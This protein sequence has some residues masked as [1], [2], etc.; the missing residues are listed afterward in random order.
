MRTRSKL[1]L[2]AMTAT[3]FMSFAVSG[4]QA[5]RIFL[6]NTRYQAIWP[7]LTFEIQGQATISCPVTLEGS[8]HSATLSKVSGQLIGYVTSAK[9]RG[10]TL[11]DCNNT[12]QARVNSET[13]PWHMRYLSFRGTLPVI[14]GIT[15]QLIG[16]NFNV[17]PAGELPNCNART[18]AA[19]PGV[20]IANVVNGAEAGNR[21]ARTL[22]ADPTRTIPVGGSFICE[23][24]A[25][26]S[27]FRGT[28][29][30]FLQGSTSTRIL[31]RLVQ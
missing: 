23:I 21:I 16:A 24:F 10:A 22:E 29:E 15:L 20:G 9:V 13:L 11:A 6:S 8:F 12:G 30:V 4:A 5:R 31:V 3:A 1:L 14:T 19:N 28:A 2:A 26:N 17:D 27:D 18:T 25:S 7:L